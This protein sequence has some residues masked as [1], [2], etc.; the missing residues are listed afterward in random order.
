[1]GA[2][3]RFVADDGKLGGILM[4]IQS[5][6]ITDAVTPGKASHVQRTTSTHFKEILQD[7]Q[8]KSLANASRGIT[9]PPLHIPIVSMNPVNPIGEKQLVA[10][11]ENLLNLMEEYQNKMENPSIPLKHVQPLIEKMGS[12]TGRLLPILDALPEASAMKDI[13]NRALVAS[14]VEVIK[15]NRGDYL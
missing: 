7:A 13:L 15:F 11:V 9:L 10:E 5:K 6:D 8:S 14:S 3:I 4:K 12:E 1:M 2:D